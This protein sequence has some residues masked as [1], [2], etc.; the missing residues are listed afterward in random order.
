MLT[1]IEGAIWCFGFGT[2]AEGN[3]IFSSS[4][5]HHTLRPLGWVQH[6]SLKWCP[7]PDLN[8]DKRFRKPLLFVNNKKLR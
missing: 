7:R 6:P 8:R 1:E 2:S 4:R 3:A 5:T